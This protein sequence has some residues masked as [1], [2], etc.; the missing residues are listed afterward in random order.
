MTPKEI[1]DYL[2]NLASNK[3]FNSLMIWGAPGIGKSSIVAKIA[4]DND[5]DLVDLRLSQLSP[6]DLR[7]L[8]GVEDGKSKWY[9]PEFMPTKGAGIL[10]LD[11]INMAPPAMQGVAQQLILDRKIGNYTVP[12]NWFVWAAGNRKEDKAA[13]FQMPSALSNR[14]IHL[15]IDPDWKS[16]N[17]WGLSNGIS[18]QILAFLSFRPA[19]LHKIDANSPAW[20]SPRS[21]AA[22]DNL[23][24]AGLTIEPAVGHVGAEFDAYTAIYLSLPDFQRILDGKSKDKFPEEPSKRY[25]IVTGLSIRIDTPERA[26]NSLLWLLPRVDSE[27]LQL[28]VTSLFPLLRS[29]GIFADFVKLALKEKELMDRIKHIQDIIYTV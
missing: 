22:A 18:E 8:P 19:L 17:D 27:W 20:P 28:M 13:V 6:T 26:V 14:F 16:F 10:F 23:F 9:V 1:C 2:Q 7:G 5:L 3:I 21:W 4:K 24:R 12:K 25:A 11:E 15:T 29:K